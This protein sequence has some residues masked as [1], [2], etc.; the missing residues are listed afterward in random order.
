[1]LSNVNDQRLRNI[2][3]K[4]VLRPLLGQSEFERLMIDVD[5]SLRLSKSFLTN[6]FSI[7]TQ[8]TRKAR[9]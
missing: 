9:E 7:Y 2:I 5:E 6:Y 3:E 4:H 1:M 8:S